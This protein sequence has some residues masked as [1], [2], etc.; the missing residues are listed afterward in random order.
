[1]KYKIFLFALLVML[2]GN[3]NAIFYINYQDIEGEGEGE[4]NKT[5]PHGFDLLADRTFKTVKH[6]GKGTPEVRYGFGF[7]LSLKEMMMS[8]MP[9]DWMA[10]IDTEISFNKKVDWDGD[11]PW[12]DILLRLGNNYGLAFIVDWEQNMVQVIPGMDVTKID[13]LSSQKI[14]NPDTGE[15]IYIHTSKRLSDSGTLIVGGKQYKV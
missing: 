12:T 3:A 8:T 6:V 4:K 1:M 15:I 10:Y 5:P 7:Q 2:S 14:R 13:D 11:L 9:K